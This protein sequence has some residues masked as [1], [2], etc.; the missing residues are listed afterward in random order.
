MC[1]RAPHRPSAKSVIILISGIVL[2]SITLSASAQFGG[3]RPLPPDEYK[4]AGNSSTQVSQPYQ[5]QA[6]QGEDSWTPTSSV[7]AP[8]NASGQSVV[9]TGSE[10]ILWGGKGIYGTSSYN[11][12]GARY[13]PATDTWQATSTIGAPASRGEHLAVYP[14]KEM[15]VWGG[16]VGTLVSYNDGGRYNPSADSWMPITTTGAPPP[17]FTSD[18]VAV[19]TGKEMIVWEKS[20]N[21]GG[22]YDPAQDLWRPITT[23]GAP[24]IPAS[25][26]PVSLH[27][28]WTGQELIV[29]YTCP[30]DGCPF[31]GGRYDPDTDSWKPMSSVNAAHVD[32]GAAIV[33]TGH[34]VL[35]YGG[36]SWWGDWGPNAG[37]RYNPAT[38]VWTLL[39]PAPTLNQTAV[40]QGVWTGSEM[41]VLG[42][43]YTGSY[44]MIGTRYDPVSSQWTEMPFLDC[45]GSPA[46][47]FGS[48][49]WAGSEL[50]IW[51]S[52]TIGCGVNDGPLA[53]L[54]YKPWRATR[55]SAADMDTYVAQGYPTQAAGSEPLLWVGWDPKYQYFIERVL[56]HFPLDIPSRMNIEQATAYMDLYGFSTGATTMNISAH[57]VTASWWEGSTWQDI[58]DSFDSNPNSVVPI[59]TTFDWYAWDVTTAVKQWGAGT[60]NY[61]IM[62]NGNTSGARNERIFLAREAGASYAPWLTVTYDDPF[63]APDT[64]SPTAYVGSPGLQSAASPLR[65]HWGG[66]DIGRGI[67]N[68][69]IQIR[70]AMGGA[71]SDWYIWAVGRAADF[72]GAAGHTYCFRSRAR[73]YAGSVGAWSTD[74]PCTTFYAHKLAGRITDNRD[75][76]IPNTSLLITPSP[77]TTT[78][79]ALTG[80]FVTYLADDQPRKIVVSRPGYAPPPTATIAMTTTDSYNVVLQPINNV[81]QNPN[82][83]ADL[84]GSW[85]VSGTLPTARTAY[86]HSGEWGL[87]LNDS[88]ASEPGSAS[89]SQIV[90]VPASDE[91]QVLSFLYTLS[92]THPISVSNFK[93]SVQTADSDTGVFMT[94][95]GCTSWC[96]QWLDMTVWQ[97]QSVTLTFQ[98]YQASDESIQVHLDEVTLGASVTP[99][100]ERASPAR[101][102]AYAAAVITVTGKNFLATPLGSIY[103]TGPIVLLDSTALETRWLSTSTLTA[104]VPST[105]PFGTYAVWVQ[106]PSGYRGAL[107]DGL[108]I[109][110]ALYLPLLTKNSP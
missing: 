6:I 65:I 79:N 47:V 26:N 19:W 2:F 30:Y 61:G 32:Q 64:T 11:N 69:D 20:T 63:Y 88:L 38:D 104:T 72:V 77:L 50:I 5:S 25:V 13:R 103:I 90:T 46:P 12:T 70:D 10:M 74:N 102:D 28:V 55:I 86:D 1:N 8:E 56:V 95:Q 31:S 106:N 14:G 4:T 9:W 101:I 107:P 99:I 16:R 40:T 48:T 98:L 109:G 15:L 42:N 41:I 27:A 62:F 89:I 105:L 35:I 43:R 100:V 97:G 75:A 18:S 91:A 21:E 67:Q 73:D 17:S 93:V 87:A 92:S 110:Q 51:G 53:G 58:S 7:N 54:R 76:S 108:R 33:W 85:Q 60:P 24:S 34:D 94:M 23:T 37:G 45:S 83:E 22:R 29:F 82:F 52:D 71:W 84:A 78:L 39:T 96:H 3:T 49:V 44:G 68:F 57:R 36:L 59:G 66:T 80:Q 81:I